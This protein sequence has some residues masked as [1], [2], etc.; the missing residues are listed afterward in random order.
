MVRV[1]PY[2][3]IYDTGTLRQMRSI[4]RKYHALIRANIEEQLTYE[5]HVETG[6][7]KPLER[8]VTF[9]AC[10]E[11]RFGPNNRF[12]AY[13][14]I[15]EP[16]REVRILAIGIKEREKVMIGGEEYDL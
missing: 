7:R 13:Y 2:R 1:H 5:P 15:V 12:R 16:D 10:W 14:R 6:N 11:L 9:D 4:E 8:P 3:L